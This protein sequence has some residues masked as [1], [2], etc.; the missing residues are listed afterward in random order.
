LVPREGVVA[1]LGSVVW[2]EAQRERS[3]DVIPCLGEPFGLRPSN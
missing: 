3:R 2:A 1:L